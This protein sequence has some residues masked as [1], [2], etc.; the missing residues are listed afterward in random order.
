LA[1]NPKYQRTSLPGR[2][3]MDKY[4]VIKSPCTTESAMKKI[5]ENNTITFLCDVLAT[6][7]QIKAAVK[8]LYDVAV[9]Q[10]NTLIRYVQSI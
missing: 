2:C 7:T 3:K 5:E 4:R 10:V 6:K 8:S 9:A 1:R